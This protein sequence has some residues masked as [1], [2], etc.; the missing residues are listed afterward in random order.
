[1][2]EHIPKHQAEYLQP[3]TLPTAQNARH[4]E[5]TDITID[6]TTQFADLDRTMTALVQDEETRNRRKMA[7]LG[8]LVEEY[9]I[10]EGIDIFVKKIEIP[11]SEHVTRTQN[12]SLSFDSEVTF[13][14]VRSTFEDMYPDNDKKLAE[15]IGHAFNQKAKLAR[16]AIAYKTDQKVK[17]PE[18]LHFPHDAGLYPDD[19]AFHAGLLELLG[20][21][22]E[23]LK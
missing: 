10:L 22:P 13:A 18:V 15:I 14:E 23:Q 16:E 2:A 19:V 1:M 6:I 5:L 20:S 8:L 11:I 7:L 3:K 17:F 12:I 4:P 21:D 9:N